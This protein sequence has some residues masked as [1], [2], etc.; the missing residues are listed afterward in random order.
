MT[1]RTSYAPGEFCWVDLA[2][3]GIAAA[4]DFYRDLF[5]WTAE[6]QDTQGGPPYSL[7][8]SGDHEVAGLGEMND[9]MKSQGVPPSWNTYISVEDV[10]KTVAQAAELGAEVIVPGMK[11][12]EAGWLAF[13]QD[14]TGGVFGIWQAGEHCGSSLVD[15]PVAPTWNELATRDREGARTFYSSLM[16]WDFQ[17]NPD[18][19][20]PYDIIMIGGEQKGGILEMN[21]QWGDIPPQWTVYFCVADVDATVARASELGGRVNV[22]AFDISVGRL[23]M[24]ADVHGAGFSVIQLQGD[25]KMR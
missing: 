16:G 11:V 1:V 22:P 8:K 12:V 18:S 23:A 20:S 25:S 13:L 7:F 21:E 6:E 9:V 3:H 5:G 4:R 24:L 10:E 17:P 19:P 14:P 15:E 2:S